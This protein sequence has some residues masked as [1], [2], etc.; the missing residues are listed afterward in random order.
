MWR[1][2]VRAMCT[3]LRSVLF[4]RERIAASGAVPRH[5]HREAYALICVAGSFE[6]V[7]YAGRVTAR[8]GEL[9]VQ[10]TLDCHANA[11]PAGGA[12]ILRLPW[13]REE[14][15]GGRYALDDLDT[16]VRLAERDPLAASRAAAAELAGKAPLPAKAESWC[17]ALARDLGTAETASLAAWA[18]RHGLAPDTLARGFLRLYGTTPAHFRYELKVRRAWL[19]LSSKRPLAEIAAE[20][21]FADQPHMTRA[22]T[23][24]TGAPPR[25]WRRA[26]AQGL[27]P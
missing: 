24:L 5:R 17:D 4:G 21:G 14:G 9:L 7:N 15:L 13:L 18:E 25:A 16:L 12:E 20:A 22:I 26:L 2:N 10:P 19:A 1:F 11:T 23:A 8:P 3:G 6:Q 27:Y